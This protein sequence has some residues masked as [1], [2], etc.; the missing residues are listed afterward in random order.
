MDRLEDVYLVDQ[1]KAEI[2]RQATTLRECGGALFL[3][4][5]WGAV[6]N[7]L[8]LILFREE[9]FGDIGPVPNSLFYAVV[10]GVILVMMLPDLVIR[11]FCWRGSRRL[12]RG[13]RC[14]R[15]YMPL[16]VLLC[17]LSFAVVGYDV[18]ALFDEEISIPLLVSLAIDATSAVVCV[19]TMMAATKVKR[20]VEETALT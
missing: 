19:Q 17:L 1:D 2:R 20:Y 16:L 11:F 3:F 6:R 7:A 8:Y 12:A 4:G 15:F 14:S 5:V 9:N 10:V 13:E 18:Y